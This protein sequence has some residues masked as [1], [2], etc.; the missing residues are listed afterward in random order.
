MPF[1]NFHSGRLHDPGEFIEGTLRTKVIRPGLEIIVGKRRSDG[2]ME[3]QSWHFGTAW[4]SAGQAQAWLIKH[5]LHAVKFA[6]AEPL[7]ESEGAR[8]SYPAPHGGLPGHYGGSAPR[9][10]ERVGWSAGE[11]GAAHEPTPSARSAVADA[12]DALPEWLSAGVSGIHVHDAP[13]KDGANIQGEFDPTSK[14][15]HFYPSMFAAG[16]G[17]RETSLAGVVAHEAGH[18]LYHHLQDR[19]VAEIEASKGSAAPTAD[20][21]RAFQDAFMRSGSLTSYARETRSEEEAF[22]EMCRIYQKGGEQAIIAGGKAFKA[23]KLA[24]AFLRLVKLAGAGEAQKSYPAPHMGLSGH[25]GGSSPRGGSGKKPGSSALQASAAT[26]SAE[27]WNAKPL[28]DRRTAWEALTPEEADRHAGAGHSIAAEQ[29]SRLSFAGERPKYNPDIT[30]SIDKRLA[31]IGDYIPLE[32]AGAIKAHTEDLVGHLLEAGSSRRAAHDLAMEAVDSLAAQENES[33]GRQIGDHGVQHVLGDMD[34]GLE[35]LRLHPAPDTPKDRASVALAAIFHDTGYL[36]PP[37]RNMLDKGHDRWGQQHFDAHLAAKVDKALGAGT[38]KIISNMIGTHSNPAIDWSDP[39]TT[40]M[41]MA[42]NLAVFHEEKMPGLFRLA[43]KNIGVLLRLGRKSID[44]GQAQAEMRRNIEATDYSDPVKKALNRAVDEVSG[45]TPKFTLGM[46]GGRISSMRWQDGHMAVSIKR[47]RTAEAL[48]RHLDLGQQ[49]FLKFAKSYGADPE[50]LRRENRFAIKDKDGQTV[51]EADVIGKLLKMWRAAMEGTMGTQDEEFVVGSFVLAAGTKAG[52]ESGWDAL[53]SLIPPSHLDGVKFQTNKLG[54]AWFDADQKSLTFDP[55][56]DAAP[57]AREV[58][59]HVFYDLAGDRT[60]AVAQKEFDAVEGHEA[61]VTDMVP[62][63]AA[64][65]FGEVYATALYAKAMGDE[66]P[67]E[68]ARTLYPIT[69]GLI[70][71]NFEAAEKGCKPKKKKKVMP[72]EPAADAV[73]AKEVTVEDEKA[74]GDTGP[75]KHGDWQ[76]ALS[77]GDFLVVTTGASGR[78]ERHLPI[79]KVPGGA[80]N[81]DIC[82]AAWAALTSNHRGEPYMGPGKGG[83][84]AKLR[85]IYKSQGWPIPHESKGGKA[86][87][88]Q[89]LDL[90]EAIAAGE[91]NDA[92]LDAVMASVKAAAGKEWESTE[93]QVAVEATEPVAQPKAK[94]VPAKPKEVSAVKS[95]ESA[96]PAPEPEAEKSY[97]A[98]HYGRPGVRGGSQSRE[99]HHQTSVANALAKAGLAS[100][101]GAHSGVGQHEDLTNQLI[102]RYGQADAGGH[103]LH[104]YIA[105]NGKMIAATHSKETFAQDVWAG[106]GGAPKGGADNWGKAMSHG[107]TSLNHDSHGHMS[108][109][110]GSRPSVEAL[111]A[112]HTAIN[113][114]HPKSLT[115]SQHTGEKVRTLSTDNPEHVKVIERVL[116]IHWGGGKQ[117]SA[118]SG[119]LPGWPR[120]KYTKKELSEEAESLAQS[121]ANGEMSDAELDAIVSAA[122]VAQEEAPFRGEQ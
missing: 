92:G 63:D 9:A 85:G 118:W 65:L 68:I 119:S 43:P 15:V 75:Y 55:T 83:A 28:N 31:Q 51:F 93:E 76:D 45:V 60:R 35:I 33:L 114:R 30:S 86:I 107:F 113:S 97:P 2:P 110:T 117:E 96:V 10:S 115:V 32:S 108:I 8:K 59:V 34:M 100:R 81:H 102:Q 7:K 112:V 46:L 11:Q 61:L 101:P 52:A 27:E 105:P 6:A 69:L 37:A 5:K 116:G 87:N 23:T 39:L 78:K 56:L 42:D 104:A 88:L 25:W 99:G 13:H 47:N 80:P 121:I 36:T 84:L 38:S 22:A 21:N 94:A 26:F 4:W 77:D 29:A 91:L 20:A 24:S 67:L 57:M 71:A 41:R 90:A 54:E 58:G 82:G 70:E 3:V 64:G 95:A 111:S 89:A 62:E 17:M 106:L 1:R 53:E 14:T 103:S 98:P 50:T 122:E 48:Q 49:Q 19:A 72:D 44:V 12:L 18:A 79:T 73:A 16:A 66:E 120:V 74:A 40:S 109:E